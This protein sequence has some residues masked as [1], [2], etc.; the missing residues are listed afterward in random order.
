MLDNAA[1]LIA[2]YAAMTAGITIA[3]ANLF[4]R[5]RTAIAEYVFRLGAAGRSPGAADGRR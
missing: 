5:D 4:A 3:V 2:T 1:M